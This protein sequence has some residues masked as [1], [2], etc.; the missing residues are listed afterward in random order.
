MAERAAAGL[1]VRLRQEAPIP[2]DA[3]LECEPG[4]TL[5]LVGPSGSGKS[6]ILRCI[7]GLRAAKAGSIEC[8]D[9]TWYETKTGTNKP[10]QQRAVGFVFQNYALFPHLTA[11]GN[12]KAALGHLAQDARSA[13]AKE[14][15]ARVHLD[16]L[17]SRRP[18]ELSGGQQQRVA[19]ARALARDP[20]VLLLD[21][22]FS[23]VDRVTRQKLYRELAELRRSTAVPMVLVTHDLDEAAMLADRMT[24]L[25]RGRTLQTG[26]PRAVMARPADALV[27]RLVDLKNLFEGSLESAGTGAPGLVWNGRVLELARALPFAPG[28][29][30]AW[31]I[32]M[33]GVLLH[34][35]D[36]PSRGEHENPVDGTVAEAYE[37]GDDTVVGMRVANAPNLLW[38]RVPTH[39]AQRNRVA[40]GEPIRASLLA[41]MI[42]VMPWTPAGT[43]P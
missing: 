9:S 4:Q 40:A 35:R 24:I 22:P 25:H 1:R 37:V 3:H 10:P 33:S 28:S 43:E 6:T 36:R 32:P 15:L 5:A 42:H 17:E 26:T 41:E 16:G 18:A 8:A 21:E 27:A 20:Q 7:A 34:R 13:R 12:V 14:L 11:L 19:V 30:V 29:R 38:L 39:V 2:L 23:A 31:G